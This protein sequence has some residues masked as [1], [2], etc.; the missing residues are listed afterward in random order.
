MLAVVYNNSTV[1]EWL[2]NVINLFVELQARTGDDLDSSQNHLKWLQGLQ[3][4]VNPQAHHHQDF[5][6]D[7]DKK[8]LG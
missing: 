3:T 4:L 8:Y 2:W 6:D 7:D 5:N 1:A